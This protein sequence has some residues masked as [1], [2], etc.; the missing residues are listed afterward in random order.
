R[1][2]I[3]FEPAGSPGGRNYGWKRVEGTV[4]R[5]Q[6]DGCETPPPPCDS[7]EYTPPLVDFSSTGA[8]C[9]VT[10]GFV[11]RGSAL[12][13]LYGFYVFG[14][15]C[16]GN[17]RRVVFEQG[18]PVLEPLGPELP[19]LV[20]FG[21]D[22]DGELYL[23]A[24]DTV[25]RLVPRGFQSGPCVAD[26]VTLCLQDGRFRVQTDWTTPQGASGQGQA[27]P[28]TD[29]SGYFWFFNPANVEVLTKVL[30]ACVDPYNR[31]W[32]FAAGLTDV[33]VRL[34]VY[35]TIAGEPKVYTNALRT[36]F[37]PVQ[38]TQAFDTCP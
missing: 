4:C 10:G 20:S 24:Q 16:S 17:V 31:Y 23:V 34:V 22:P 8:D 2:E 6:T 35:D 28:L 33:E 15:F 7:P 19:G 25:Y 26:G 32:V 18:Q 29:D 12:P 9:A 3:D 38:D 5:D 36:P 11:Y 1:E 30:R 37:Q 14:D 27:V 21:E 13:E